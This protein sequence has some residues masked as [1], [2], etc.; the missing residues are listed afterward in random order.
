M[1]RASDVFIIDDDP[2]MRESLGFLLEAQGFAVET[3]GSARD[4]LAAGGADRSGCLVVDVR[5]PDMT[6]LELQQHLAERRVRLSIIV[7]TGHADVQMAVGAMKAGAVDFIEKPFGDDALLASV[8]RALELSRQLPPPSANT[9][10]LRERL[11]TL[12]AREREVLQHLVTGNPHKVIGYDLNISPRT[13]EVHRA[14]IMQKLDARNLA[15]L[16]RI[17]MAVDEH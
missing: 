13:I 10:E 2:G 14:R 1:P 4:F 7:I 3:F 8:E 12:T 17:M 9:G 11:A 16:V 5:M 6:G 15:D